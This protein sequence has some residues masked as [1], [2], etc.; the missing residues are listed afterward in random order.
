MKTEN[1]NI[2][3]FQQLIENSS[4]FL[5]N[6][7]EI[8]RENGNR[9]FDYRIFSD[10][11]GYKFKAAFLSI[12]TAIEL[13]LK[14]I[15]AKKDWTFI[16]EKPAKAKSEDLMSGVFYSVG[17]DKCVSVLSNKCNYM[18]E[19]RYEDRIEFIRTNRNKLVHYNNSEIE[20]NYIELVSKGIDVY[21]DLYK[22]FLESFDIRNRFADVDFTLIKIEKYVQIRNESIKFRL[23]KAR[24]PESNHF[25][26]CSNCGLDTI[27]FKDDENIQCLFCNRVEHIEDAAKF[28]DQDGL[29]CPICNKKTMINMWNIENEKKS[30]LNCI[31]CNYIDRNTNS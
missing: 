28:M 24:R 31:N 5:M 29:E 4:D 23:N 10:W 8:L 14:S 12:S 1:I 30:I 26:S 7:V 15:I 18:I 16:F 11:D 19:K 9:G 20:R 3:V 2:K 17:F 13:L 22:D 27:I 6:S 25:S 21:L